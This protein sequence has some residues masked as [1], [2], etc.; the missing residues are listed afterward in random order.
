[1]LLVRVVRRE[2]ARHLLPEGLSFLALGRAGHRIEDVRGDADRDVRIRVQV[3]VPVGVV[4][5]AAARGERAL[6]SRK[7]AGVRR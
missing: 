2:D 7:V 4:A 5:R 6:L 3:L 1:M